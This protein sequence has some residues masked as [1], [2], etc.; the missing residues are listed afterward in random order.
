VRGQ[1][2]RPKPFSNLYFPFS[3]KSDLIYEFSDVALKTMWKI[4]KTLDPDNIMDPGKKLPPPE[5]GL[6]SG[7]VPQA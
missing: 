4:K 5:A 7:N 1:Q 6:D 3:R 2:T